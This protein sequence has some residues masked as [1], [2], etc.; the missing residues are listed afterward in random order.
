MHRRQRLFEAVSPYHGRLLIYVWAIEQDYL[1][2]RKIPVNAGS[3]S[4][5]QDVLVP[6]VHTS[7]VRHAA[8]EQVTPQIYNRYYHMF[9]K[10]ELSQLVQSAAEKLGLEL[11]ARPTGGSGR[12]G[13]TIVQDG[14]ER[15]NYYVEVRRWCI[16]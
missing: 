8:D 9:A 1:S 13:V 15:S 10:G 12:Q 7:C 5:G 11:G 2:K 16:L 3:S 14:W 4:T 6:W